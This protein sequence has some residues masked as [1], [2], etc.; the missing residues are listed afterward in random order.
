RGSGISF[1]QASLSPSTTYYYKIYSYNGSGSSTNYLVTSPL[2]GSQTTTASDPFGGYYNSVAGLSGTALKSGLHT[3]IKN[4]HTTVFSYTNTTDE[5][6]YTDEDP[7]ESNN[8]IE[9]YTGWSVPKSSYGAGTTDWNKEHTWSDSHGI[10]GASPAYTDLHHLRPCDSTVNSQKSNRDFDTGSTSYVDASPPAG[11]SGDTG[12]KYSTNVWEPR[13]ADKGDVARMIFYMA[14]RYEGTDTSYDL[15]LTDTIFSSPSGEPLYAKKTTLLAWHNAD[16]PNAWETRRNNR[17]QERQGNRNPF[18]DHPEYVTSIWGGSAPPTVTTASITSITFNSASG[19]G[20]VTSAGS[21]AVTARGVCWN[22][23]G[24][25]TISDSYSTDGSGVG[26]F[27]SALTPLASAQLYYVRA[28]ATNSF[29]TAYGIEVSFSTLRNEPANHVTNFAA[30][31]TTETTIPLSWTDAT[32]TDGYLIKGSTVSFADIVAPTDYIAETNSTLVHNV[33]QGAQPYIFQNL[34]ATTTYYFKIFPYNNSGT[35]INYKVD[36]TV[37]QVSA[38]TASPA[39]NLLFEENF[40]YTAGTHLHDNGWAAHSGTGSN[41]PVVGSEN[42]TY[43]NY[44]SSSGLCGQTTNNGEDVNRTF[45]QQTTGNIYC[46]FLLNVTN[47]NE[48][49]GYV[50]HLGTNTWTTEYKGKVFV[51][52]DGSNNVAFGVAK[53]T[54]E[55]YTGF[56]YALNTTYLIVVKYSFITGTGNDEVKMWVNPDFSGTEPAAMLTGL[57]TE[58]DFSNCGGVALRQSSATLTAKFDGIRVATSWSELFPSNTP[59]IYATGTL[60]AF[61]TLLGNPSTAQQYTVSGTNLTENITVTAPT[62]FELSLTG[63]RTWSSTVYVPQTGG[64][65]NSTVYVRF[66]PSTGGTYSGNITHNSSGAVQVNKAVSGSTFSGQLVITGTINPFSTT[67]GTPSAYQTYNLAAVDISNY[68]NVEVTGPFQI[69]DS[70]HPS[71]TW[72]TYLQLAPDYLGDIYVRYNPTEA[73]TQY[74]T[75]NHT[76]DGNEA[77]PVEINLSGTAILAYSVNATPDS[78]YFTA[79]A[80]ATSDAQSYTLYGTNLTENIVVTS[81]ANF[82]ISTSSGGPWSSSLNLASSFNGSV[83]VHFVPSTIG[84]YNPI[85][86]NVS[87]TATK[88]VEVYGLATMP[89]TPMNIQ[90]GQTLTRNFDIIGT[91][92]TAT[93]PT[94]WRASKTTT[95]GD[96]STWA[97]GVTATERIGGNAMTASYSNGIYNFGAGPEATAPDRAVGFLSSSSATKSGNLYTKVTNTGSTTITAFNVSYKTEKYRRGTNGTTDPKGFSFRLF[98]SYDGSNWTY[99]GDG[100]K[101]Y[102]APDAVTDGYVNAPGD[103]QIISGAV[104]VS[105]PQN[106]EIY[107][108]WNY[109]VDS[110]TYTSFAQA[111]GIDDVSLEAVAAQIT[112]IPAFDPAPGVQNGPQNVTIT[113]A[114]P[115]A[116]IYY[117]TNG[118]TPTT[119]SPVYSTPINVTTTSTIKAIAQAPSYEQSGIASGLFTIP[120]DVANIAALRAMP[121]GA[122]NY[123]RLTGE[124]ILT[125]QSSSRNAKY[126]QDA[127]GAI[128]IDDQPGKITTNYNLYDG[129]T[130]IVGTLGS[131]ASMMQFYPAFNTAPATS[132][133]NTVAPLELT[134]A[135]LNT[136]HQGKLVKIAGVSF[137]TTGNFAA[138]TNYQI[139]DNS[140]PGVLRTHYLDLDYIGTPIPETPKTITCVILQYNTDLQLVPRRLSDF[141]DASLPA[142]PVNVTITVNGDDI[143][144]TWDNDPSITSW[145]IYVSEDP[146]GD[147]GDVPYTT[148]VTNS[149]TLVNEAATFGKRFY[150]VKAER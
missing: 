142:V 18:I 107:F 78:L 10:N 139:T 5:L 44:P 110:G 90:V 3:L 117:T 128:L 22:T 36:G 37:P 57:A 77:A 14:T 59:I 31:T 145:N 38:M 127:T 119:S 81:P 25:P 109:G 135:Q 122:G 120:T 102:F 113:C 51:K 144:L 118:D 60:N 108:C 19:G 55:S 134:L 66:N 82:E 143:V 148:A 40:A 105:V 61:S 89:S 149:K 141:A 133:N 1:S 93:L 45:T 54:A 87:G 69:M 64:N 125:L 39:T 71:P 98:Y 63:S 13:D 123:Y 35:N 49:T 138:T 85:I 4:T 76:D 26:V 130:N 34:T 29:G 74:G 92:A 146:Y 52:K 91:S 21:A 126:I 2:A 96:K 6:K 94:G 11:Y 115:N 84:T 43:A 95:V 140:N 62:G 86:T 23:T 70:T 56:D 46:S 41:P 116:V 58:T 88:N 16:P 80:G 101:A 104:A 24:N 97:A 106:A 100:L 73:G 136:S 30:G 9:T 65:A 103:M 75:I 7:G 99:A 114:T 137:Q 83:Y 112:Q 47:C 33:A 67:V 27:T 48:A 17:I 53:L 50:F 28:Y 72:E 79:E 32:N 12:C 131:Y 111:L 8:L 129:I 42:L 68:V 121:S 20:E 150:Y 15:E 124:A 132:Q 147:F